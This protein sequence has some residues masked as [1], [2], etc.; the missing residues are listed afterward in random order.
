[1]TLK[2]NYKIYFLGRVKNKNDLNIS[3]P[4]KISKK[5]KTG[6]ILL[7]LEFRLFETL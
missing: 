1:M 2:I 6:Y 3:P 5:I 7:C 4:L